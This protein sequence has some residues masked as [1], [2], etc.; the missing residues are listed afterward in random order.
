MRVGKRRM[1]VK[2]NKG[3]GG[4]RVECVEKGNDESGVYGRERQEEGGSTGEG[5]RTMEMTLVRMKR[6]GRR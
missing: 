2:R 3:K 4:K 6:E 1:R 5:T